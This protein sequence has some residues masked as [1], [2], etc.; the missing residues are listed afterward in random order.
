[1]SRARAIRPSKTGLRFFGHGLRAKGIAYSQTAI[2]MDSVNGHGFPLLEFIVA[3]RAL[4]PSAFT[5]I[6]G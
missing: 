5:A 4:G 2:A 3:M 1:M 6:A